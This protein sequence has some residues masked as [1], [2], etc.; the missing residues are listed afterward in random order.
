MTFVLIKRLL[1]PMATVERAIHHPLNTHD[2][3]DNLFERFSLDCQDAMPSR[4]TNGLVHVSWKRSQSALV[5]NAVLILMTLYVMRMSSLEQ[6]HIC[7]ACKS[8]FHSYI[9]KMV[10]TR[11]LNRV[12]RCAGDHLWKLT[13]CHSIFNSNG[14]I[15]RPKDRTASIYG[16]RERSLAKRCIIPLKSL[17]RRCSQVLLKLIFEAFSFVPRACALSPW[18]LW[19]T[20]DSKSKQEVDSQKGHAGIF[21]MSRNGCEV[22]IF[23]I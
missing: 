11:S 8:N 9:S 23:A 10:Q 4:R 17:L 7:S 3:N 21:G 2:C 19:R 6:R 1:V 15:R 16:W 14:H 5:L 18:Y 20:G 13:I 22:R 12:K